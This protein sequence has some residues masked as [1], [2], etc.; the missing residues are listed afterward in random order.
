MKQK[1]KIK[2]L[3][4]NECWRGKRF[5]TPKY[6]CYE[7][8]LLL[9]L[10]DLEVPKGKLE[11]NII[12]GFSSKNSDWDNPI[13]PFQDILQKKYKFNDRQVYRATIDKVIV[14]KG[15]EFIEFEIIQF[16]NKKYKTIQ[17]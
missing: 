14:E 11:I 3:S 5:K 13:K 9:K 6:K 2:P 7:I 17:K 4:V 15:E 1:I 12:F 8:E 10:E 16:D